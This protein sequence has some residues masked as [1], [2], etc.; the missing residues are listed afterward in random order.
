[1]SKKYI[2]TRFDGWCDHTHIIK[3]REGRM[4]I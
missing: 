1:M 3:V 2:A 4:E